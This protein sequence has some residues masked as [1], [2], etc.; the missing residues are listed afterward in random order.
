MDLTASFRDHKP[1][2]IAG[3]AVAAV[4]VF[5]WSKNASAMPK[6]ATTTT[7]ST[8]P[9]TFGVNAHQSGQASVGPS[10]N[11]LL[12]LSNPNHVFTTKEVQYLMNLWGSNPLPQQTGNW[13]DTTTQAVRDFQT[14]GGSYGP[15]D[16][17]GDAFDVGTSRALQALATALIASG[18]PITPAG[19]ITYSDVQTLLG[20]PV[21]GVLDP[22]TQARLNLYT[23]NIGVS[24][25]VTLANPTVAA[26]FTTMAK[27]AGIW[28]G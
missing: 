12:P 19:G 18:S 15:M 3:G 8:L 16:V 9:W 25:P 21:T 2:W 20:L 13:D 28:G 6:S 1:L 24:A 11:D 14:R 5:V 4:L 27:Q 26:Y 22:Q 17:T 23:N 10:T 7:S